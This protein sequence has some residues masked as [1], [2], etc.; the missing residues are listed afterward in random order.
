MS[1]APVSTD[2]ANTEATKTDP[3]GVTS[4][5]EV[6]LTELKAEEKISTST[7]LSTEEEK[8]QS[9]HEEKPKEEPK[10]AP[11]KDKSSSRFAALARK[12]KEIRQRAAEADRAAAEL[13]AREEALKAREAQWEAAKAK[14]SPMA[15]LKELGYSYADVTQDVLGEYKAPPVDPMD[16]RVNP[17]KD[18][19]TKQAEAQAA[20]QAEVQALKDQLVNERRQKAYEAGINSIRETLNDKD[21]YELV[22]TMGEEG[23]ELVRDTV[24]EYWDRYQK[25]LTIEEA[26]DMVEKYYEK[27]YLEKIAATKK[28]QSRVAPKAAVSTQS[29]QKEVREVKPT[30]NNSLNAAP[31]QTPDIDS[32]SKTD[33]IAFLAKKLSYKES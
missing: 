27:E 11:E 25:E 20:L 17:L 12:D 10:K 1:N 33:A 15:L 22:S 13:K 19:L 7:V 3:N 29:P 14:K 28:L 21:R 30:L 26:A 18:S 23:V 6:N 8:P 16:E 4:T 24:V 9:S 2:M 32:M 31:K 5:P